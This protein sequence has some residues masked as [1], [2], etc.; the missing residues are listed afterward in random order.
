MSHVSHRA[1]LA[2]L[3]GLTA[4]S[5][6]L[7]A[8]SAQADPSRPQV[9]TPAAARALADV[10]AAFSGTPLQDRD[11]TIALR[12]LRLKRSE[13][14]PAARAKAD[15]YLAR[16]TEKRDTVRDGVTYSVPEATPVCD[17]AI[18]VH[19]VETSDDA[20]DQTD[21]HGSSGVGA[22]NGIP[23]YIDTVLAETNAIHDEYVAAGYRA[24]KPDAGRG[25]DNRLD[26][27]IA[28]TGKDSTYG[29]CTSDDPSRRTD[30]WAFCVFD[31]DFSEF[32]A[33]NP[34]LDSLRVTA[35]HEYF[36]AVQFGY[37]AAEDSWLMEAT[38]A[39]VEDE[40]Y[41][42][43]DDNRQYLPNSP[44]ALPAVSLDQFIDEGRLSGWHYGDWI[45]FRFLTERFPTLRGD[46]PVLVH[47]IWTLLDSAPGGPDQYSWQ[48]VNSALAALGTSAAQQFTN[49]SVANLFPAKVYR[50]A[51]SGAVRYP[52]ALRAGV[53]TLKDTKGR[54][55]TKRINHLASATYRFTPKV[56]ASR[57]L[58]VTVDAPPT[59]RGSR[60]IVT[61][62]AKSGAITRKVVPL[63]SS[64]GNGA[65]TVPFGSVK[66]VEVTLVNAS[67]RFSCFRNT[68]FSCQGLPVD[69]AQ[70]FKLTYKVR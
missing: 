2:A 65:V 34:P 20:P 10:E 1:R 25:G 43:V 69:D 64:T 3:V 7:L 47:D 59:V 24:P 68:A 36:H 32:T 62:L 45:F 55:V 58:T 9:S 29:Y 22:S 15:A 31:N 11:L 60:A 50:D 41:P 66:L 51:I 56:P 19:Y 21:D 46:L 48:G 42:D 40:V 44:L 28:N 54:V 52:A 14:S 35:A 23:D 27:Y 63:N 26:V 4:L 18:C 13:L 39:W 38:A 6:A 70:P 61:T 67:G 30:V 33:Q 17:G 12:D 8:P 5:G 57:R 37:D 49:F 16:P 53:V